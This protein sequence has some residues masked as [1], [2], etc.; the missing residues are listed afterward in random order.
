MVWKELLT[1]SKIKIKQTKKNWNYGK[2]P[3]QA[4]KNLYIHSERKRTPQKEHTNK[5]HSLKENVTQESTFLLICSVEKL[6]ENMNLL[7]AGLKDK[8]IK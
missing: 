8:I 3:K 6:T 2:S 7:Q 1:L 5:G 4:Y